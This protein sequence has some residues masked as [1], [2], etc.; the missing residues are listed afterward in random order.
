[1]S[2]PKT[3]TSRHS[4][5]LQ[6]LFAD[7]GFYFLGENRTGGKKVLALVGSFPWGPLH[8]IPH[9]VSEARHILRRQGYD[10][11]IICPIK[12]PVSDP[13]A[14]EALWER[15]L[16]DEANFVIFWF[17]DN[18]LLNHANGFLILKEAMQKKPQLS[19]VGWQNPELM[20]PEIVKN[21]TIAGVT[22]LP[23]L[24]ILCA[25]AAGQRS[26]EDL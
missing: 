21:M 15:S 2:Q 6:A 25:R 23:S 1:M 4:I 26:P 9:W 16:L 8:F 7:K 20:T 12:R 5:K 19:F 22:G 13:C 3:N 10:G 18:R 14:P 11:D 24:E 17:E